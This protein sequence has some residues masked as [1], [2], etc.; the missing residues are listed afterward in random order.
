M[1]IRI[2]KFDPSTATVQVTFTAGEK[3]HTRAVNAVLADDGS[4]DRA[5]TRE[6]AESVG[7]GV[8]QKFA[9]GAIR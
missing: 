1:Q 6:R 9:I 4:Y 7:T 5:A 8:A 2:G 3:V